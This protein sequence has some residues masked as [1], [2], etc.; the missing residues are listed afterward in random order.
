MGTEY[1]KTPR[2]IFKVERRNG[3]VVRTI[4]VARPSRITRLQWDKLAHDIVQA[5]LQAASEGHPTPT[6]YLQVDTGYSG[7]GYACGDLLNAVHQVVG[8]FKIGR[9]LT[10]GDIKRTLE[11]YAVTMG[12]L[13]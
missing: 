3:E 10:K 8:D 12:G 13:S 6:T 9:N 7:R 4:A 5:C 1:G 11:L 2:G